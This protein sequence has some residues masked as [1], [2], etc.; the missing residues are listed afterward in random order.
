MSP[1]AQAAFANTKNCLDLYRSRM[2]HKPWTSY[3]SV[4]RIDLG[5]G[6]AKFLVMMM[7]DRNNGGYIESITVGPAQVAGRMVS[8]AIAS[9]DY[10]CNLS[11]D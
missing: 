10:S 11:G 9:A 1:Q 6:R 8:A 7:M 2:T 5:S 4:N 3:Q